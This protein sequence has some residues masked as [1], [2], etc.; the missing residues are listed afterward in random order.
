MSGKDDVAIAHLLI[1][2]H[3]MTNRWRQGVWE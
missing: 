3:G 1:E 2:I